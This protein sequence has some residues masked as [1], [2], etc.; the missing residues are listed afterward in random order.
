M[1]SLAEVEVYGKK[2]VP[3][4]VNVALDKP[5]SQSSISSGGLSSR[6]VDGNTSGMWLDESVTHTGA[7]TNPFWQ[8]DLLDSFT[9][10]S[11]K[12]FNRQDCCSF[13]LSDFTVMIYSEGNEVWSEAYEGAP[14]A[15]TTFIVPS[16]KGDVVKV[17]LPGSSRVL[18]LAEVEVYG[19]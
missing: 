12:I 17:T 19:A 8:V 4:K 15:E 2:V 11:I 5:T 18:S 16:I 1:L 13:R 7:D 9:I 6:A 14:P 10:N 3:P